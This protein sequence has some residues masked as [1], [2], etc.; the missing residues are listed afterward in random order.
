VTAFGIGALISSVSFE[1]VEESYRETN[2]LIPL[3]SGLF[4]GAFIYFIGNSAIG[5]L[6][7]ANKKN[8]HSDDLNGDVGLPILLGTILDGIPE[9]LVIGMTVVSGGDVSVAMIA[10][11]FISNIPEALTSSKGLLSNGWKKRS[12]LGMWLAVI[13]VSALSAVIGAALFAGA[14]DI[15]KSFILSFAGGAI[16][17]MLADTMIPEAY[18][19]SGDV[20]GL[21]VVLGFCLAFAM[22][23]FG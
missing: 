14:P 3:A 5:K 7:G 20:T 1:L 15:I 12:V 11:V 4:I 16:L 10:A 22:T 23:T 17:T 2:R 6:A 18:R 19:E 21:V 8:R 13:T 9:S